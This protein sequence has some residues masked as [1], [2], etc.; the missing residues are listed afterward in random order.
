MLSVTLD[1]SYSLR[2][3]AR[4]LLADTASVEIV[5]SCDNLCA[6]ETGRVLSSPF[7]AVIVADFPFDTSRVDVTD[8]A[9]VKELEMSSSDCM[10]KM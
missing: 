2:V 8:V 9:P 7:G 6:V 1:A 3:D 4:E 5:E 10:V